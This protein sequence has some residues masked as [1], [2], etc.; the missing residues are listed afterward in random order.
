MKIPNSKLYGSGLNHAFTLIELLLVITI[1]AILAALS[2]GGFSYAQ[3]AASRNRTTAGHAAIK[4]G[5]EQYK[6]KFGEYPEATSKQGDFPGKK[7][8]IGGAMMLFQAITGNGWDK[9]KGMENKDEDKNSGPKQTIDVQKVSPTDD[10]AR[11]IAANAMNSA[12]PKQMILKTSDG[13]MLVD[14]FGRPF[15]YEKAAASAA[16]QT[17]VNP[18]YDLWSFGNSEATTASFS[19]KQDPIKSAPWI[20]NW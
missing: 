20:K 8:E 13:Y 14:G 12:L 17:T 1:I 15:Q 19:D 5:L 11:A 2:I 16:T 9:I 18:T 6:E 10:Q 7:Y 4:S 3:N